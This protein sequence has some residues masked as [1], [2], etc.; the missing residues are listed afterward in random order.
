MQMTAL[1]CKQKPQ[2]QRADLSHYLQLIVLFLFCSIQR[3]CLAYSIRM[4]KGLLWMRMENKIEYCSVSLGNGF[5]FYLNSLL[6]KT[7]E[8]HIQ[9]I[10]E[11]HNP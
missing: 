10:G 3:C 9:V 1:Y 2:E 11:L 4:I 8:L 6:K 7:S 5:D